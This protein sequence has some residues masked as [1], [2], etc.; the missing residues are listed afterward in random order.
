MKSWRFVGPSGPPSSVQFLHFATLRSGHLRARSRACGRFATGEGNVR[1]DASDENS[2]RSVVDPLAVIER[3]RNSLSGSQINHLVKLPFYCRYMHL[4]RPERTR[5]AAI[6]AIR[7]FCLFNIFL[8][9]ITLGVFQKFSLSGVLLFD[10]AD[11]F[12][13]LAGI[14]G[15]LAYAPTE[16]SIATSVTVRKLWYR[17]LVLYFSNLALVLASVALLLGLAAIAPEAGYND[18]PGLL[19][20]E[21]GLQAYFVEL[22]LMRQ[23]VGYSVVLRLYVF[24]MMIAP[25]YV[26]LGVKRYWLPL[27]PAGL[28]WLVAGHFE[29][30]EYNSLTGSERSMTFLAWNLV[31]AA[32]IGLGAAIKAGESLKVTKARTLVALAFALVLPVSIG[33]FSRLSPEVLAWTEVRNDFFWT[34]A[35]KSLQSPMR[36]ISLFAATF[37]VIAFP[38]APIIRLIHGVSNHNFFAVLGRKSL[39]VFILGALLALTADWGLWALATSG[40]AALASPSAIA[41]EFALCLIAFLAMHA[42]AR[43]DRITVKRLEKWVFRSA[44]Q[45]RSAAEM[46]H[47]RRRGKQPLR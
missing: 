6:D 12:V 29:I 21:H 22:V 9:H 5:I 45:G 28:I 32:G 3:S 30:S 14:S 24:L 44:M 4:F 42:V 16:P 43:S 7:G 41:A 2:C 46:D 23:D 11:T 13:F 26:L 31:F 10:S 20:A 19:I 18:R 40:I 47:T 1:S 34:G 33:L 35:S 17:A 38:Q 39:E 15:Y 8:N 36:I 37:I 25:I 27:L